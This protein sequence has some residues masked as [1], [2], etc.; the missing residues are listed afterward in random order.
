MTQAKSEGL[1]SALLDWLEAIAVA[2]IVIV[3]LFLFAF[4]V[5]EVDGKSMMD[6]LN[7][8]DRLILRTI[9]YTPQVGDIVVINRYTEESLV[10]RVIAK[11]G[12]RVYIDPLAEKLYVNGV[13]EEADYINYPTKAYQLHEEVVVPEGHLFVM[14][15]HRNNSKDSRSAE[16]GFISEK[17]VVGKVIFRYWPTDEMGLITQ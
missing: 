6:T 9:G 10:K 1:L 16:I 8:E 3:L 17:D 5:V 2:L 11:A 7:D 12:D 15:D 14:G 4:R 13:M